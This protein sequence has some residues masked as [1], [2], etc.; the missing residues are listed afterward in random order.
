MV[1]AAGDKKESANALIQ[2]IE[3]KA[4]YLKYKTGRKSIY[5]E[6]ERLLPDKD[7]PQVLSI[8]DHGY[9]LLGDEPI[10]SQ[11]TKEVWDFSQHINNL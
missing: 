1:E 4:G 11:I 8:I 3:E 2:A 9:S 5:D 6:L 7:Y 10:T